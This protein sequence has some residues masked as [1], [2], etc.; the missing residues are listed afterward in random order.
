MFF[1][2]SLH[3]WGTLLKGM[4]TKLMTTGELILG[5]DRSVICHEMFLVK[6]I[7]LINLKL[8]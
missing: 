3:W 1:G 5:K 2:A 8:N 4:P 7:N 6:E